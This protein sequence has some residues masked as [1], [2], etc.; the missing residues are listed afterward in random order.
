MIVSGT[1]DR[2]KEHIE[3]TYRID[4][5]KYGPEY[6]ILISVALVA[7][8]SPDSVVLEYT[9]CSDP[10]GE[11]DERMME[12]V[13]KEINYYLVDLESYL[14]GSMQFTGP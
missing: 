9:L 11:E 6:F 8:Y 12:A 10:W 14:P 3:I 13:Q 7:P 4:T 5:E 2:S 1:V